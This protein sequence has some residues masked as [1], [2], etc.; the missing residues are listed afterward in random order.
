MTQTQEML[1]V[2]RRARVKL[3]GI[4]KPYH[5]PAQR[6]TNFDEAPP[7]YSAEQA[8]AEAARC[9][10]CKDPAPCVQ[11]CPLGNDIPSALWYIEHGDF[12]KAIDIFR[13][14]STMPEICGRICPPEHTCKGRC[15]LGKQDNSIHIGALEYFVADHQRNGNGPLLPEKAPE[16]GKRVAVVGAG[17]AGLSCAEKL[18]IAG[19]EV[20]AYDAWPEPGGLLM[21]GVPNFKLDRAAVRG[22]ADWLRLLGVS[23]RCEVKIGEDTLLDDLIEQGGFQL[24]QVL[25]ALRQFF[26]FQFNIP[27][28]VIKFLQSNQFLVHPG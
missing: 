12:Q 25:P 4:P 28:F 13:E 20:V 16:T 24:V 26:M 18:A 11:A 6:I 22:K 15:V 5:P 21:Y 7:G 27:Q 14:S 17:P 3:P 23:F 2:D 10:H 9:I 1:S 19:H 8:M